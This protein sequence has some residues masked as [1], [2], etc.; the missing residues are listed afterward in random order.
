MKPSI[1]LDMYSGENSIS[2]TKR[3]EIHDTSNTLQCVETVLKHILERNCTKTHT[4]E[5]PY[6]TPVTIYSLERNCTKKL[7]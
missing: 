1:I 4:G 6:M 3:R 2:K 5:K 7:Y